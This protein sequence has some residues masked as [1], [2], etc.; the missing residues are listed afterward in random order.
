[1]EQDKVT[2]QNADN[3][4]CPVATASP[5]EVSSKTSEAEVHVGEEKETE[6]KDRDATTSLPIN[7]MVNSFFFAH[8]M[9]IYHFL[10]C[11]FRDLSVCSMNT[12]LGPSRR[13]SWNSLKV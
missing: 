8:Y 11:R 12:R 10:S 9:L 4:E 3:D 2:L 7:T 5:L 1:M 13:S 6:V